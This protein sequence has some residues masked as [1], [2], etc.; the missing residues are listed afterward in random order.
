[1]K[2]C[3]FV[4]FKTGWFCPLERDAEKEQGGKKS[5]ENVNVTHKA[6]FRTFNCISENHFVKRV[7]DC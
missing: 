4:I 6:I 7:T 5:E 1:M 3:L 2:A